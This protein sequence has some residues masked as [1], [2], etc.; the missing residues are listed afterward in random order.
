MIIKEVISTL[1]LKYCILECLRH[2]GARFPSFMATPIYTPA[3]IRVG[4]K[5]YWL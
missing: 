1:I 2:A 3:V 4:M 5:Y